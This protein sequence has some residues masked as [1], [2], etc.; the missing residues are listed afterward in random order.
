M[1]YFTLFF[2]YKAF[3]IQC[4]C[5][6]FNTS[7]LAFA[8][9]QAVNSQLW[10]GLLYRTAQHYPAVGQAAPVNLFL[11]RGSCALKPAQLRELTELLGLREDTKAIQHWHYPVDP[12]LDFSTECFFTT[13]IWC[14]FQ[15]GKEIKSE[16]PNEECSCCSVT[17]PC[18]TLWDPIDCSTSGLSVPH[19]LPKFSQVHILCISDAIQPS[20]PWMLSSSAFNLSKHQRL[21][22]WVCCS[23]QVTKIL[24][25]Q[26]Q[27]HSDYSGL[28]SLKIDLF[29]LLVVQETLG[30]LF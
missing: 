18:P 17:E 6:I 2:S 12:N 30:S 14:K 4:V 16:L 13:K 23:H 10:L 20:H 24:E 1:K 3:E 26:L 22:Q 9:F 7:Q 29:D 25:L 11:I 5:C 15:Q 21:F 28:I 8:A 27:H 19:Q